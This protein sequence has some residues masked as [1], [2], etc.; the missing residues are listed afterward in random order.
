M[1]RARQYVTR[2]H[3]TALALSLAAATTGAIAL[4]NTDAFVAQ[5]FTMALEKNARPQGAA[6]TAATVPVS[7]PVSGT[8]DFWL[9]QVRSDEQASREV[10][11][12]SWPAPV[13]Q[14]ATIKLAIAGRETTL[15]V[16]EIAD[17]PPGA[18]RIDNAGAEKPLVV[19]TCRDAANP[20]AGLIRLVVEGEAVTR[21]LAPMKQARAL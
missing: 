19:V 6:R 18:T 4:A 21:S 15:E 20:D 1:Q 17:L 10:K 2:T 7:G 16:V 3:R 9:R 5:G 8:E 11:L 12:A 14:G 13:S